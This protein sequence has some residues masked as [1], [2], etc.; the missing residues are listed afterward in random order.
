MVLP[1]PLAIS[2]G[3]V[4][5]SFIHDMKARIFRSFMVHGTISRHMISNMVWPKDAR[6]VD[7]TTADL[8][9]L[10]VRLM[11]NRILEFACHG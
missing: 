4:K 11:E 7:T 2:S 5:G 9:A 3:V 8:V 10:S 1:A 6:I